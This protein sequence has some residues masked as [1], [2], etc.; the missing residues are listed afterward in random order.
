MVSTGGNAVN[1]SAEGFMLDFSMLVC[2]GIGSTA[3][4]VLTA[5]GL[6]RAG[7]ALM[8]PRQ[9]SAVAVKTAEIAL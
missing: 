4:G 6:F 9:K 3:F 8:R 2:A 1:V 5:Y 7:F